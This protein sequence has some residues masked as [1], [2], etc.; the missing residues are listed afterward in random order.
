MHR[1]ARLA[2][3]AFIGVAAALHAPSGRL[4]ARPQAP[5]RQPPSGQQAGGQ[6]QQPPQVPTFKAGVNV[7]RVDVIASDRDGRLVPGLTKADFE[8]TEDGRPQTIETLKLVTVDGIPKPGD[9][10]PRPIRTEH[11][12]ESEA[13]RDDVRL[14]AIFFD[15]YHVRRSSAVTVKP[16]LTAFV[17]KQLSAADLCAIMYPQTPVSAM[18]LTRSQDALV[19]AIRRFEGR[20]YDYQPRHKFE[21]QYAMLPAE[22][23]ERLRN[24]VTLSALKS[25]V[26]RMGSLRE[27]RKAVILVSEGFSHFLPPQ[28][29]DPLAP[30]PGPVTRVRRVPA[31]TQGGEPVDDRARRPPPAEPV[32]ERTAF[33]GSVALQSDL[34]EVYDAANRNNTTI[35]TLDP[36][37]LATGEF[38]IGAGVGSQADREFLQST[39]DT[40]RTLADQTDGRAIINRNDAEAGLKQVVQDSSAYYLIGYSSTNVAPDGKF[41]EIKVRAKRPGVRVRARRGYWALTREEAAKVAAPTPPP[42]PAAVTKALGSTAEPW[43]GRYVRSWLGSGKG[44]NGKTRVTFVWEPTPPVPGAASGP[45]VRVVIQASAGSRSFYQG[46]VKTADA[47]APATVTFDADPGTMQLRIS[48]VSEAGESLDVES[49]DVNVP[50]L[51]AP[52]VALGTPAVFRTWS[53]RGFQALLANPSPVPTSGREFRRTERLLVRFDVYAPGL[54]VPV[55]TARVLS[56]TGSGM[57]DLEIRAPQPPATFHQLDLPLA[58]FA[59]GEYL[60]EVKAKGAGGEATELVPLKITG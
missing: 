20:K 42:V 15:D 40:L 32:E 53:T 22:D 28:L 9:P 57:A 52:Q 34:R 12:E 50:D 26:I 41:H 35:Y 24:Q 48:V 5:P 36:R 44:E 11:D 56:R 58:G 49:R 55:V 51:T 43:R 59:P 45:A 38:D 60:I 29:I 7:V 54:E 27:G 25:L 39:V 18:M 46:A 17:Q 3:L 2:G 8:V 21:E 33:F 14:Y 13:A 37:G 6:G 4:S 10:A 16:A 30:V 23:V 31:V 47:A 1:I 19:S